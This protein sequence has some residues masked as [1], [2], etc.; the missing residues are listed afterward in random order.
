MDVIFW[1]LLAVV[2]DSLVGLIGVFS[3]FVKEKTLQKLLLHLVSFASGALLAGGFYHLF[4]ESV[5]K[6]GVFQAI[7]YLLAGFIIFYLIEKILRWHH[8]HK[9]KCKVHPFSYLILLGD[10]I[11]NVTD[12]IVIA[13]SFLVN[14]NFGIITTLLIIAHEVPQELGNFATAVYGGIKKKKAILFTFLAQV[15]CVIGGLFGYYFLNSLQWLIGYILSFTAGGF[16][17]ISTS[18]LIPQLHEEVKTKKSILSFFLFLIGIFFLLLIK[19]A[20]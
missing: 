7:N 12:G 4:L 17:Y 13:A 11:H 19:I 6:I 8:C 20:L 18:D 5:E 10:G 1:V 9:I 14:I 16:I 3:L 15:T 2:I